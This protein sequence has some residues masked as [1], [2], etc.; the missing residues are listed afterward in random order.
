VSGWVYILTNKPHAVLYTGVT[1]QLTERLEQHRSGR[2]SSFARRYNCDLLV[3]AERHDDIVQAIWRERC[4]KRWDRQW[5]LRLI[6]E[7]N[8]H[9]RYLAGELHLA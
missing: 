7:L 5:K 1:A 9:W 2:G 3:F 8:P 4:I 6:Q